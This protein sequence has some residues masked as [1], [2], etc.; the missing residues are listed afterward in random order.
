MVTISD[1]NS[2]DDMDNTKFMAF[3]ASSTIISPPTTTLDIREENNE[4]N[5]VGEKKYELLDLIMLYFWIIFS[6][7]RIKEIL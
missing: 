4:D 6:L 7:R 3:V 5:G 2:S 1:S